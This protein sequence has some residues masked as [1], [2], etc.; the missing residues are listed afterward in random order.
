MKK[1]IT[2]TISLFIAVILIAQTNQTA[3]TN[4]SYVRET[5]DF[6]TASSKYKLNQGLVFLGSSKSGYKIYINNVSGKAAVIVKDPKGNTIIPTGRRKY[7][8]TTSGLVCHEC[9]MIRVNGASEEACYEVVCTDEDKLAAA[10]QG[11]Q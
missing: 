5:M 2:T 10:F 9:V 1:I 4:N 3:K 8:Q 11:I 7:I 6:T